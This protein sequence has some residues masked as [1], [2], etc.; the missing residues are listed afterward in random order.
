MKSLCSRK[1]VTLFL[2][3]AT[4]CLCADAWP[5]GGG[6]K[7]QEKVVAKLDKAKGADF[8]RAVALRQMRSEELR[9]LLRLV[10]E[11]KGELAGFDAEL[12]AMCA[13]S[14]DATYSYNSTNRTLYLISTNAAHGA[15]ADLPALLPHHTFPNEEE[16]EEF[17]R[18]LG[19]K[20]ITLRQIETFREVIREKQSEYRITDK[21]LADK[22]G[23][24]P[25]QKYRFD[26][27]TG[28]L[29]ETVSNSSPSS[30]SSSSKERTKQ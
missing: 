4:L 28:E 13:M 20:Q 30:K 3:T 15:T 5:F 18:T 8:K 24:K 12:K 11:K 10:E 16:A 7:P 17:L 25:D 23:I 22:Y 14:D 1:A 29:L 26:D 9:V 21:Y 6:G 27:K 2:L 19:A